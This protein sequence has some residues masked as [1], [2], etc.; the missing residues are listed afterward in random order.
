MKRFLSIILCM[1]LFCIGAIAQ[2]GTQKKGTDTGKSRLN[3]GHGKETVISPKVDFKSLPIQ[4]GKTPDSKLK[5]LDRRMTER[6]WGSEDTAWGRACFLDTREAYQKYIAM[7]PN[8]LH[9]PDATKKLIDMDVN[10]VFNSNPDELPK[11]TH[12]S[13]EDTPTSTLVVE[14]VTGYVLTVM[15]SGTESKSVQ[16]S[17]RSK[18]SFSLKNGSYRIAASV[19]APDVKSYAGSQTFTGGRY[20][21]G[22][23]ITVGR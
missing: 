11:M 14:N 17:P 13:Q 16:I 9:R 19:P 5:E 4:Y 20:E 1:A 15:Y 6:T 2:T 8:G 23:C 18:A 3:V 12:V 21:V 10:D 7:Y 22:Y